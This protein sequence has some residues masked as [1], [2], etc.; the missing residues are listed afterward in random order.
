MSKR[1]KRKNQNS[2]NTA[3]SESTLAL[4]ISAEPGAYFYKN[5]ARK[6]CKRVK[7]IRTVLFGYCYHANIIRWATDKKA[8]HYYN[9][10]YQQWVDLNRYAGNLDSVITEGSL[11]YADSRSVFLAMVI[12]YLTDRFT[13]AC[14]CAD[15]LSEDAAFDWS[16]HSKSLVALI[17]AMVNGVNNFD[18]SNYCEK[19]NP[20]VEEVTKLWNFEEGVDWEA[21]QELAPLGRHSDDDTDSFLPT[22]REICLAVMDKYEID[23]AFHMPEGWIEYSVIS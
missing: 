8:E 16:G 12:A 22:L 5:Q 1:K 6:L 9:I 2:S 23:Y 15:K 7:S 14:W 19:G 21:K 4:Q 20:L 3:E 13:Y 18:I 10:F 17:T 11:K